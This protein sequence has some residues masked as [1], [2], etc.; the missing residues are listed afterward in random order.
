[1]GAAGATVSSETVGAVIT[2]DWVADAVHIGR[3]ALHIARQSALM[4]TKVSLAAMAVAA[5]GYLH[6]LAVRCSKRRLTLR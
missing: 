5:A 1:M 6:P 3:R 2:V 4:G